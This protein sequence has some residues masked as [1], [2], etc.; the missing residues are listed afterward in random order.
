MTPLLKT[1]EAVAAEVER[2]LRLNTV[3][4]GAET[5]IGAEVYRT[6]VH[7]DINLMPCTVLIEADPLPAERSAK[8]TYD[9]GHRYIAFGYVAMPAGT[10]DPSPFAHAALRDLKRCLF[11]TDGRVSDNWGGAV[12]GV[13]YLGREFAPRSPGEDFISVAFEFDVRFV[14]DMANP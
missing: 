2:R 6:A 4:Q 3:A 1:E 11:V 14:E 10:D 5:D 8:A 9:V 12:R 13:T 7:P